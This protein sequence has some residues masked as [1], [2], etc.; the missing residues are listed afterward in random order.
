[1][2]GCEF[3]KILHSVRGLSNKPRLTLELLEMPFNA[4]MVYRAWHSRCQQS[5][6]EMVFGGTILKVAASNAFFKCV[7]IIIK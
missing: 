4:D 6:Y 2:G 3:L 1:M 5:V 7:C